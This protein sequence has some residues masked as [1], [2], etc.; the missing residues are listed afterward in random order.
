MSDDR[1]P[2]IELFTQQHCA[3]CHQVEA[4]L[5]GRGVAFTI[6]RVD[7]DPAALEVL[8]QQGYMVT[9]VVRIGES[10][11]AGFNRKELERLLKR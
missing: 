9:P 11:I 2:N 6:H 8:A 4:F 5:Q 10:W 3:P 1:S 7:Q